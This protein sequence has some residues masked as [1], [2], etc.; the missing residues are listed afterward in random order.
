M[1][2]DCE[3]YVVT[4][5]TAHWMV[6]RNGLLRRLEMDDVVF[7]YYDFDSPFTIE[8]PSCEKRL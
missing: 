5:G 2:A 6:A 4:D 3:V 8:F 1:V 7:D